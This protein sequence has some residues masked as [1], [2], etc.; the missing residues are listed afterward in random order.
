MSTSLAY[1]TQGINGFQHHSFQFSDGKVIQRLKRKE[2]RCPKCSH[3]SVNTYPC[4][5]RRIQGLPYG[6]MPVYFEVELH[7]IYCPVCQ[8]LTME[9]LPFLSHPKARITKALERTIIELRP[10]MTIHAIS[11]YFHLDWRVVKA[12][13]KRYL[14][15]KFKHVKLK[16]VKYIGIDEIAIGHTETGKTAYWTIVRDL[17]SGSVLHVVPGK[18]IVELLPRVRDKLHIAVIR[19]HRDNHRFHNLSVVLM[20]NA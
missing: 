5:T 16:H 7:R 4:R 1:H 19:L 2:F 10:E 15:R 3:C 12:C 8:N 13:E 20:R 18:H 6:R 11:K 9:E 14:K 17:D